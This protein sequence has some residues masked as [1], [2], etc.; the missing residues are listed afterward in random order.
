MCQKAQPVI[1]KTPS[2][3]VE[4]ILDGIRRTGPGCLNM[5][6]SS[7]QAIFGQECPQ[8]QVKTAA[9][10]DADCVDE[11]LMPCNPTITVQQWSGCPGVGVFLPAGCRSTVKCY[12]EEIDKKK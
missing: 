11:K 8:G 4:Q 12:Y 9:A 7:I 2:K 3:P 5:Y 10:E 1:P 6:E